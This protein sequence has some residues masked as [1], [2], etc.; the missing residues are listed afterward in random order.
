MRAVIKDMRIAR[1][2]ARQ[3]ALQRLVVT[4]TLPGPRIATDDELASDVRKG[5]MSNL[6]PVGSCGMGH[7]PM[8]WSIRGCASME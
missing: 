1:N 5:G 2:T 3:N 6:H 7:G 8:P 4:E